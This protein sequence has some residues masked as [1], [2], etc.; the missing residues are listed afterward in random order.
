VMELTDLLGHAAALLV[1]GQRE[2]SPLPGEAHDRPFDA[3]VD[4][5]FRGSIEIQSVRQ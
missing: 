3:G 1:N 4:L 5:Q 2:R